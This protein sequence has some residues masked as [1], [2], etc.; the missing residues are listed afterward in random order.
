M[1]SP[2]I[3]N[4]LTVI[5]QLLFFCTN[6]HKTFPTDGSLVK[7]K[8]LMKVPET[9]GITEKQYSYRHQGKEKNIFTHIT[10]KYF[11]IELSLWFLLISV[12]FP[13]FNI[14]QYNQLFILICFFCS[15]ILKAFL[16]FKCQCFYIIYNFL[17]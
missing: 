17:F 8:G 9:R 16:Y 15:L 2:F 11:S 5:H 12:W 1:L 3:S 7:K 10:K 4:F 13:K 6:L 14:I